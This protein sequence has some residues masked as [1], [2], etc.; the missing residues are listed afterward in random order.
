MLTSYIQAINIFT[1]SQCFI[2]LK[3]SNHVGLLHEYLW[4]GESKFFCFSISID[5]HRCISTVCCYSNSSI[6]LNLIH[7]FNMYQLWLLEYLTFS[8]SFLLKEAMNSISY[9]SPQSGLPYSLADLSSTFLPHNF[10]VTI[11]IFI[12]VLT[13]YD[14]MHHIGSVAIVSFTRACL[15]L[16]VNTVTNGALGNT[17]IPIS[18]VFANFTLFASRFFLS[19]VAWIRREISWCSFASLIKWIMLSSI[20]SR[21]FLVKY[22]FSIITLTCFVIIMSWICHSCRSLAH[23]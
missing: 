15:V 16:M 19:P 13:E 14:F 22:V 1:K 20:L 8:W 17:S 18:R 11:R 7:I 10:L 6:C 12:Y 4:S 3:I 23:L 9:F 2:F 5:L 21:P